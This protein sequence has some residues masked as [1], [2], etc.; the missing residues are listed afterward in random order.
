LQQGQDSVGGSMSSADNVILTLALTLA[1]ILGLVLVS[2]LAGV[3]AWLGG[4]GD[5]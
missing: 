5:K 1:L 2:A 3:G 4:R